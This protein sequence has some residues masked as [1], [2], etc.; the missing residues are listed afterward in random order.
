MSQIIIDIGATPDDSLGT[1]LRQA[2]SDVNQMF[3]EVYNAGPATSNVRIANNTITTTVINSNLIL[4][5]SGIGKVQVNNS[6]I[7]S[8]DNVYDLGSPTARFNTA[9]LGSGGFNIS[10]NITFDGNV[11]AIG[12]IYSDGNVYANYFIGNGSQ[13]TGID[14]DTSRVINGNTSI[15]TY[16]NGNISVSVAGVSNVAVF[17]ENLFSINTDTVI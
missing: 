11:R 17:G 6:I 5:P 9:Y 14:F 10:G 3:T 7:P 15:Q 1:P 12:N 8:I 13:L 4:S 2:F 16:A